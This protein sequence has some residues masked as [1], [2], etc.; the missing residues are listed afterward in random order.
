MS[1][2]EFPPIWVIS[3]VHAEARRRAV[4]SSLAE[5]GLEFQFFD[6][7]D[8]RAMS[9]EESSSY[10]RT[11]A[12][13]SIGRGLGW[14]EIGCALSHLSVY[15]RILES[16]QPH[17]IV[18]EDDALATAYLEPV[19]RHVLQRPPDWDVITFHS[20]FDQAAPEPLDEDPFCGGYRVCRYLRVP[21][22]AQ[23]YLVTADAA[24]TLRRVAMPLRYPADD[25]IFREHPAH[26]RVVGVEPQ[27]VRTQPVE[28]ELVAR[29]VSGVAPDARWFELPLVWSGKIWQRTRR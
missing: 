12:L 15:E 21:F 29:D 3:L 16:G 1:S 5:H 20:L 6:A 13:F 4:G 10:S 27:V 17:A 11:R 2:G 23:C 14:G 19:V 28:S 25:L 18:M 22:G 26:L 7:I 8:A 24:R 9:A